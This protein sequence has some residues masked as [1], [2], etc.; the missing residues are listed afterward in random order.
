L[1]PA[2]D[3]HFAF[4]YSCVT[5][6]AFSAQATATECCS[7]FCA[8]D[9]YVVGTHFD[10]NFLALIDIVDRQ[11]IEVRFW[12]HALLITNP[13]NILGGRERNPGLPISPSEF[14]IGP[15]ITSHKNIFV[16]HA[17]MNSWQTRH[18]TTEWPWTI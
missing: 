3:Q 11:A 8:A 9:L 1:V 16:T 13:I 7:G 17:V 10:G 4:R 18:L 6:A 12:H 14:E 15:W 2:P 5:D